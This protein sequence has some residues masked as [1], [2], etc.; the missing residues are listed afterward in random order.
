MNPW[1]EGVRDVREYTAAR[2]CAQLNELPSV[3]T[4]ER[5]GWQ[6]VPVG[7]P[8]LREALCR[9]RRGVSFLSLIHI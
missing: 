4:Q 2:S 5:V 8:M 7:G 9:A 1:R 6:E 3:C